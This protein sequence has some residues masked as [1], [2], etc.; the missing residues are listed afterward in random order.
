MLSCTAGTA[1][2]QKMPL[3][4]EY[5]ETVTIQDRQTLEQSLIELW[6]QRLFV[7]P[8]AES[9]EEISDNTYQPFLKFDGNRIR[10]NNYVGFIQTGEDLIEIFPKVFRNV[11]DIQSKRSLMLRH[12]FYWFN[13]CRKWRFPFNRTSLDNIDIDSFPEL[14]INLIANQ[15]VEAVSGNPLTMYLPLEEA[16][17]T[18]RGSINFARYASQ[19]LSRGNFHK[20]EC[21]YE[22]FL[23]DNKLNRI[24][25][26]CTRL[27]L[28]QT[29]F[30][31]NQRV[32]QEIT[33][34]LSDVEDR[35]FTS[36]D[37]DSLSINP[38][39]GEY[40]S[41]IDSCRT[42]LNQQLYSSTAYDLSQWC[43]LF[44]MEYIFEDFIAGFLETHFSSEWKVEYQKS[45]R[46][47]SD[48]P[49]AFQMRHDIFLTS[50]DGSDRTIIVDPKY[51]MRPADFKKDPKKGI[52]QADL[53]QMLAYAVKRGCTEV[54]LLYPN[55]AEMLKPV[56]RFLI[57]SGFDSF[58]EISVTAMEIPFWSAEGIEALA[59]RQKQNLAEIFLSPD[60]RLNEQVANTN[61]IRRSNNLFQLHRR[62]T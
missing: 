23:F 30:A 1:N 18:P 15:F 16:L 35:A 55:T 17:V 48:D 53:Y 2:E 59:E 11:P 36:A 24:I 37:L 46:Y 10:A 25:K 52:A 13:Y 42:V 5:G 4:F 56:D 22:P 38:F 29:K 41:V 44:P 3:L 40:V 8:E 20:L 57:R 50:R 9:P 51:K 28:S 31:E 33:F 45:D 12:I 27:L 14:I 6:R 7:Y 54:V 47:V 58:Y 34:I 61:L 19:S 32:L 49:K 26:Y 43:L 60:Y 62:Q 21:D 39:F